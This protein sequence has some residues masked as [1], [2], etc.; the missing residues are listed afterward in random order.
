M[1]DLGTAVAVNVLRVHKTVGAARFGD[2][3]GAVHGEIDKG[4]VPADE[5]IGYEIAGRECGFREQGG[6]VPREGDHTQALQ[7]GDICAKRRRGRLW[8]LAKRTGVL[9]DEIC[10]AVR[11]AQIQKLVAAVAVDVAGDELGAVGAQKHIA[12]PS[13]ERING[14]NGH[15]RGDL[16]RNQELLLPVA[17]KIGI[18]DPPDG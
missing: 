12:A 13:R 1:R 4:T 11:R 6:G 5:E 14:E 9:V 16:P 8:L 15:A 7:R 3:R 10:R 17:G 2:L 18:V